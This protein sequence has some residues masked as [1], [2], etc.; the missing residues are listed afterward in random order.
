M[1]AKCGS[2]ATQQR[3]S[4]NDAP[5]T[6]ENK[7]FRYLIQNVIFFVRCS[8]KDALLTAVI[9]S[10]YTYTYT[11]IHI[12]HVLQRDNSQYANMLHCENVVMYNMSHVFSHSIS[13][14]ETV[15][16]DLIYRDRQL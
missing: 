5:Q 9:H 1:L 15:L 3:S 8:L 6:S 4:A 13:T 14:A 2:V 11:H 12:P 7:C 10:S 16:N